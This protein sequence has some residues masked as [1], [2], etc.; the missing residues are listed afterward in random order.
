MGFLHTYEGSV[1]IIEKEPLKE[2]PAQP[3]YPDLLEIFIDLPEEVEIIDDIDEEERLANEKPG[4]S[5]SFTFEELI[6]KGIDIT[7]I[8]FNYDDYKRRQTVFDSHKH[9]HEVKEPNDGKPFNNNDPYPIDEKIEE[10]EQHVP[11]MKIHRIE[12]DEPDPNLVTLTEAVMDLSDKAEKRIVQLENILSTVIRN[13]FRI[14][15]RMHI[16]CVYYGGQSTYRKYHTI[17]CLHHD[18]IEDGQLVTL[19]QCLAC[20]RYEPII[21]QVYDIL[22]ETGQSLDIILDDNQMSYSTMQDYIKFSKVEEFNE[23]QEKVL[24]D[25]KKLDKRNKDDIDF[26]DVWDEGFIMDWNLVPVEEQEHHVNYEDG[27]TSKHLPSNYHN[28]A[29]HYEDTG[30]Y[31]SLEG[32]EATNEGIRRNDEAF[33]DVHD[34]NLLRYIRDGKKFAESN[35]GT[36]LNNMNKGGYEKILE[37]ICQKEGLDPLLMMAIIVVESTGQVSPANDPGTS[38]WG[39]MQVYKNN[40]SAGYSSKSTL[41]KARENIQVGCRMYKEKLKACWNTKNDVLGMVSYNS[42]E[43]VVLGVSGK[44][45]PPIHTPGLNKDKHNEWTWVDIAKNLERNARGLYGE[46]SVKEKMTY[47]PRIHFVYKILLEK[48]GFNPLKGG[49]G[50]QFPYSPQTIKNKKIYFTSDFGMRVLRSGG[51][52]TMHCGLDFHTGAGTPICAAGD[53]KVIKVDFQPGGAGRYV[54]ID[55]GND[56]YTLYMHMENNSPA[57]HGISV[58]TVVKAGQVIG[59]ES[60]TGVSVGATGIHLHFEVRIGGNQSKFAVDPKKEIFPWMK[61][62]KPNTS[63]PMKVPI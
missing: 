56:I 40:L 49:K 48:K 39:L 53:G 46:R 32:L 23:P 55:H 10:L 62:M 8:M 14:G 16:N 31:S 22:D 61:G 17:R 58:G 27:S 35:T 26:A 34:E 43:G 24:I 18:R 25:T 5:L 37:E 28:I 20:T 2:T 59:N 19:D 51:A 7:K 60:N 6:K 9:R 57:K 36:A 42:G 30:F 47:Y 33:K 38:Y 15:S 12:Y 44:G 54:T 21:G 41:D 3:I 52:A 29:H 4:Y 1:T 63:T 50:L 45:V 11:F 13:L